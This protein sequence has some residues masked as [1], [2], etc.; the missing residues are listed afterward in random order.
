MPYRKKTKKNFRKKRNFKK[1]RSMMTKSPAY[2]IG[3]TFKFKTRYVDLSNIINPGIATPAT[4]VFSLNGLYDPDIT[5]VGHQPIGFDQLMPLYDHY[6]VIAARAR[7]SFTNR[8]IA[9][10]AYVFVQLKDT[11][12]TSTDTDNILE[13]GMT[14][15]KLLGVEQ[16]GNAT[17]TLTIGLNTS[18]FFGKKVLQDD[19]FQGSISA[20]PSDQVYLHCTAAAVDP[21]ADIG[22]LALGIEIE[23]IAILTEPKQLLAS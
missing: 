22:S 13:N 6:C 10:Q 11:A 8:D 15:Y 3:K 16:S 20:N 1:S 7:V 9:Q 14:K 12:T 17:G 2:P 4:H 21:A 19:T 5:G 23:Y 18:K